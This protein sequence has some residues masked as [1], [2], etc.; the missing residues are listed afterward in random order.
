MVPTTRYHRGETEASAP[1]PPELWAAVLWRKGGF[2]SDSEAGS[3]LA[4][5]LLTVVASCR[6]QGRRLLGIRVAAG[7]TA[8][9]G[10]ARHRCSRPNRGK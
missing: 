2:G 8:L 9:Q 1:V 3:R 6:Q 7:K 10:T 5:R 4:E